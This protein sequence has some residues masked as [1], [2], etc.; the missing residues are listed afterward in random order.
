MKSSC[1]TGSAGITTKIEELIIKALG[2]LQASSSILKLR[3]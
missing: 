3:S 2:F 1:P